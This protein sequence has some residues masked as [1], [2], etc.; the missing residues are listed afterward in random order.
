MTSKLYTNVAKGLKL[1]VRKVFGDNSYVC[2]SYKG[3]TGGG[4][5]FAPSPPN[6]NRVNIRRETWRQYLSSIII[7]PSYSLTIIYSL[8]IE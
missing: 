2:R 6:L 5:L 4:G 3:K 1:K 8:I 7:I